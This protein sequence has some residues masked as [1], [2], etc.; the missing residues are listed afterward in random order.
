MGLVLPMTAATGVPW[1]KFRN[2]VRIRFTDLVVI[3]GRFSADTDIE[4]IIMSCRKVDLGKGERPSGRGMF[5][6]LD[7]PPES[8]LEGMCIGMSIW[9]CDTP[10]LEGVPHGGRRIKVGDDEVGTVMDCPADSAWVTGMSNYVLPQIAYHIKHGSLYAPR[11]FVPA[12]MD[13]VT[14]RDIARVGPSH[15]QIRGGDP[16]PGRSTSYSGPF[17]LVDWR[18]GCLYPALWNNN[19][20]TQQQ[21]VVSPDCALEPRRGC[22]EKAVQDVWDTASLLHMNLDARTTSQCLMASYTASPVVGGRAWPGI[23]ALEEY[24]KGLAVWC[25]STL[26]I[27]CR[28]A[29]SNHEQGGRSTTSR[30]AILDLP[31]PESDSLERLATTFDEFATKQFDRM[32]NLWRDNTRIAMDDAMLERLGIEADLNYIR[33]HLCAE[34]SMNGGGIPA[35]LNE[36]L[37]R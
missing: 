34:P 2:L 18:P 8:A 20:E 26:G 37:A 23:M 1:R 36:A 30:T 7:R 14:L 27:L 35:D 31:V 15:L 29:M 33:K 28:W 16:R 11:S 3:S 24:Q 6:S 21:M 13:M 22:D 17:N 5:V 32:M 12:D 10:R 9:D 25:N 4:E 19:K